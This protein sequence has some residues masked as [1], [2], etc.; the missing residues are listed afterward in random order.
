MR[1]FDEKIGP[2]SPL[3]FILQL[4]NWI[5]GAHAP[6]ILI[7][8]GFYGMNLLAIVFLVWNLLSFVALRMQNLILENKKISVGDFL[9]ERAVEL[10]I[11]PDYILP[12]LLTY[13]S[14]S[15]LCWGVFLIGLAF[16]WRKKKVFFWISAGALLFHVGMA[17]FYVGGMFFWVEITSVDKLLIFL[18]L[19]LL[20]IYRFFFFRTIDSV[21]VQDDLG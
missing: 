18:C 20:A 17:L 3:P 14:V 11:H 2:K 12:K 16:L 5:Y 9:S 8:I 1:K 13:Y 7:Q 6:S 21:L 4:R 19:V 15:V 10:E